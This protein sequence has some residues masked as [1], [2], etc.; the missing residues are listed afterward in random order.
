M[1]IIVE[2]LLLVQIADLLM[3]AEA[4]FETA[5]GCYGNLLDANRAWADAAL[6]VSIGREIRDLLS[7]DDTRLM[8]EAVWQEG[9]A[10]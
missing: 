2:R 4:A 7:D 10:R 3:G 9:L 6:A 1:S 8:R 5:A